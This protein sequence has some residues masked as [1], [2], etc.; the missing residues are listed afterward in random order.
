MV[1]E[2]S[3]VLWMI[4]YKYNDYLYVIF[5]ILINDAKYLEIDI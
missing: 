3:N 1:I 5:W 2:I 4:K